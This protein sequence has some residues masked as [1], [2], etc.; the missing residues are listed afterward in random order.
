VKRLAIV[1]LL[2]VL[3]MLAGCNFNEQPVRTAVINTKDVLTKCNI[4]IQATEDIQKQFADRRNDLKDQEN[5]INKL[6][7]AQDINE[8]KSANHQELQRLIRKYNADSLQ[9]R[10]DV[11]AEEAVK[12]KPVV[13]KINKVLADYAKEKGLLSIQ[14]KNGFAYIDPSIDIT[15]AI[16]KR[17]DQ[18]K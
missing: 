12:F 14:D 3:A 6:R 13:D 17:I 5:A 2:V 9:L 10:K 8:P 16:I 18:T 7:G 4:G 1:P 15:D 11:G